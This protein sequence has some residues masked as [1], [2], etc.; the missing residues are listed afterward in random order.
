MGY[1]FI[2]S[3]SDL[4][5]VLTYFDRFDTFGYDLETTG[6]SPLDSRILLAQIGFPNEDSFVVDARKVSLSPFVPFLES[7]HWKKIFFNGKFDEQFMLYHHKTPILNVWDCYIAQRV[8]EPESKWGNSFEDLA[9]K[10]LGV[11][12]DKSIRKTF[13]GMQSGSFTDEQIRYAAEDVQYLF[14]LAEKQ[15]IALHEHKMLHVAELEFDT[16]TVVA[17]MEL[18]GVPINATQWRETLSEYAIEHEASRKKM[19]SIFMGVDDFDQQ[20]GFF[21]NAPEN[22]SGKKPLNI[23]SPAQLKKAFSDLGIYVKDT[24]EQTI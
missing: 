15:R 11:V 18:Q 24:K 9:L 4:D 10:E 7:R 20:L 23:N 6:L 8:I 16:I 21:G 3:I 17:N 19:L 1:K 22:P 2:E 14:P 13:F 5:E 12:M